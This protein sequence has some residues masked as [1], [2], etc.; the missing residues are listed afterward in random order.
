MRLLLFYLILSSFLLIS[1][2]STKTN[3][4]LPYDHHIFCQ[5]SQ[6]ETEERFQKL[7]VEDI[8]PLVLNKQ[9][10][11]YMAQNQLGKVISKLVQV[12]VVYDLSVKKMCPN[13]QD[14]KETQPGRELLLTLYELIKKASK[15]PYSKACQRMKELEVGEIAYLTLFGIG[16]K[17]VNPISNN[18]NSWPGSGTSSN[19]P[20]CRAYQNLVLSQD[21]RNLIR[22]QIKCGQ[23]KKAEKF[24]F[25][26]KEKTHGNVKFKLL[27]LLADAYK[28][29]GDSASSNIVNLAYKYATKNRKRVSVPKSILALSPKNIIK[30]RPKEVFKDLS[31]YRVLNLTCYNGKTK[32]KQIKWNHLQAKK[33]QVVEL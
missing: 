28:A 33:P 23:I 26:T 31:A 21:I 11:S 14:L 27:P 3:K 7:G 4:N 22:R 19:Q 29:K 25:L 2:V 6:K 15:V 12:P 9:I 18:C 20:W 17:Q 16:W 10:R 1:C 8:D 13:Y 24:I 30:C 5:N 32:T